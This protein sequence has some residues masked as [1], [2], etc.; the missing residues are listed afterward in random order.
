[1]DHH[2]RRP[3]SAGITLS[4]SADLLEQVKLR[5]RK[6][7]REWMVD[8]QSFQEY[9]A[10]NKTWSKTTKTLHKLTVS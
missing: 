8:R 9:L 4:T 1:M 5:A 2:H 10:R 6:W 3:E 7:G